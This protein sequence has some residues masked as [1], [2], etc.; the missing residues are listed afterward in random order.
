MR[1]VEL[2][3]YLYNHLNLSTNG[4]VLISSVLNFATIDILDQGN[5]LPYSL[6]LPTYTATAGFHRKLSPALQEDVQG[7]VKQAEAY[8][9]TEYPLLLMRRGD[10]L[11]SD[12]A[13][14][15]HFQAISFD[16]L[17]NLLIGWICVLNPQ[18]LC[19]SFSEAR[20]K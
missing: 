11:P 5:D 18:I 9:M 17:L 8:A 12:T 1:A 6:F 3:N 7:A 10:V 19:K 2:A 20:E 13:E 15:V 4:V 16:F 14:K